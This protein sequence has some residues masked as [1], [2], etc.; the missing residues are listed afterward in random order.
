MEKAERKYVNPPIVEAVCEFRLTTDSEWDLTVPGLFYKQLEYD[1][2]YRE[3]RMIQEVGLT[4]RPEGL[5]QE[6]RT[7]ERILFFAEDRK[8]FVQLS[9]HLLAINCLRPYPGWSG[10]KPM[11]EKAF[12]KLKEIIEVR[13]LQRIGLRYINRVEIPGKEIHLE[14]YF[15]FRPLLGKKLPQVMLSFIVGCML[16]FEGGRDVLKIELTPAKTEASERSAV[17]LDLD[18]FLNQPAAISPHDAINW[19][20]VAHQRIVTGFEGCITNRSRE[21]FKEVR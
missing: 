14:D 2:P 19:V 18:Y 21:I 11:I 15:E 10:F 7:T 17:L 16:G 4:Q 5:L 3:Q 9:P 20:E 1:F 6:I 8:S 12:G 13:G